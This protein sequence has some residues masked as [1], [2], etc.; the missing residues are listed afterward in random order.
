MKKHFLPGL[1][2][3]FIAFRFTGSRGKVCLAIFILFQIE[4]FSRAFAQC[5]G[6]GV[7]LTVQNPSFDGPSQAH[8]VPGPW[9][10]CYGTPD[11][12][13]GQWGFTQAPSDG[14]AYISALQGGNCDYPCGYSE[15]ASQQLSSCM[16]AGTTY[17]FSLDLAFSTVYN[18]AEPGSC[19]GSLQIMGGNSM[20]GQTEILWQSGMIT[21]TSWQTYTI[22]LTPSQNWCY[23]SMRPYFISSCSGYINIM[24][25]NLGPIIPP[26][27][28]LQATVNSDISCS[29]TI[30]GEISCPADSIILS[31]LFNGSPVYANILTDSTWSKNVVYPFGSAGTQT[32]G[33]TAYTQNGDTLVDTLTFNLVEIT[34]DFS[35]VDVCYGEPINFTCTSTITSGTIVSHQWDFGDGTGTS[36]LQNPSYT[37]SAP[38]AYQ[39]QLIVA[40]DLGC[41][42]S[43]TKTVQVFEKPVAAFSVLNVCLNVQSQFNNQST[44]AS[45]SLTAASWDFG[46]GAGTSTLASPFYTYPSTGTYNVS[47][48]VTSDN[49]CTDTL[50]KSTVVNPLPIADFTADN[51]CSGNA[52]NF[53]N[54][55][56]ISSGNVLSFNWN[57]G[58]LS[59]SSQENPSHVYN[60]AGNYN[61]SLSV[62]SDS[63]CAGSISKNMVV[64]PLPAANF[65]ATN[66]CLDN[67]ATFSNTSTIS[68]GNI[69]SWYWDFGDSN[70]STSQNTSHQYSSAGNFNVALIAISDSSCSDTVVKQLQIYPEP[71]AAFTANNVC[72]YDSAEFADGSTVSSGSISSF[73]W[74]FDDGF[75]SSLQNPSHLYGSPGIYNIIFTV[76]TNNGC[77][78]SATQAITI[79]TLPVAAFSTNDV[80]QYTAAQFTDAS[81]IASG[82]VSS[83]Q[84][85][86]ND[87]S[88]SSA[89]N[90]SHNFA[91]EGIYNVELLVTS[92]NGC[93]DS[94]TQPVT[95]FPVPQADFSF[96]NKCLYDAVQFTDNT[97]I[98]GGSITW[99]WDFGDGVSSSLQNPSHQYSADGTYNVVLIVIS[100]NNCSDTIMKQ[101][102]I[103]P[104]PLADFS[105]VDNCLSDTADF[106]DLSTISGGAIAGWGWN[107]G[108]GN[109]SVQQ[110]PAHL[111]SAP[112]TYSVTLIV[113]SGFGCTDSI[114]QNI[115]QFPMPTANFDADS[116]CLNDL[117]IFTDLSNGNG[118]NISSWTWILGDGSAPSSVQNPS[119]L[120]ASDGS[121][122]VTLLVETNNG[123]KD[124]KAIAIPV[125]PLP[126]ADFVNDIVC[127]NEPPTTFSSTSSVT[128][129]I[130]TAWDWNFGDNLTSA[131]QNPTHTYQNSGLFNTQLI[132]TTD[133]GCNDTIIKQVEVYALPQFNF[134][135]DKTAHC[136][137]LCANFT[138]NAAPGTSVQSWFW[139]FGDGN[140]SPLSGP[141]NCYTPDGTYSVQLIA[142]SMDNCRDTVT[143]PDYIMVF[144]NPTAGFDFTPQTTTILYP[145]I[146]FTDMS[147]GANS[148]L[149]DFGDF[150]TASY[151]NP[152]H[153][154]SD[155]G[156]FTVMQV[157]I[158]QFQCKDTIYKTV[159]IK[160][161]Y[162]IYIPNAFTPDGD[163]INDIFLPEGAGFTSE[164]YSLLIF[165]RWGD[166][167][168]ETYNPN[169]FWDGYVNGTLAKQDVYVFRLEVQ[170]F[171]GT[172]HKFIGKVSLLNR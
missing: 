16:I 141:S 50:T 155:T 28:G 108:D 143:K 92:D 1:I 99:D 105:F 53:T 70:N 170:D 7:E 90:P 37:Y 167:V 68:T 169:G 132:V 80:C 86:F 8:V 114:T 74:D 64:N 12:Q 122:N 69:A 58:D 38:G 142:T 65:S 130:I 98:S 103:Y 42:D 127:K 104:V 101:D 15:G 172:P 9:Q 147:A 159:I 32:I 35:P 138:A 85:D 33:I 14:T 93:S 117:T 77:V 82:S 45:G 54:T 73:I 124:Y 151:Q 129:G 144:P 43:I 139:D 96:D 128:S 41:I 49:G 66:V 118:D 52:M 154:Y 87:G 34:P 121:Y 113:S 140:T 94:V 125:Y 67:I 153:E 31:G 46:D 25:D 78:D 83:Y 62:N 36:S 136:D 40:S 55:S 152:V 48:I 100:G 20:C 106:T 111:Y 137:P 51:V 44:I 133:K 97:V 135:S 89:Q 21:N 60:G 102:T 61:V 161:E 2:F 91:S 146:D 163:G 115:V 10:A 162:I 72:K 71:D 150:D 23:I 59:T 84:W 107:F 11:T 88:N 168:Y 56:T 164:H 95:I 29:Q 5:G 75:N 119:H 158:N 27:P 126:A 30:N 160:T 13:P 149:W 4:L 156:T 18:T 39:V 3:S 17:S 165:D 24:I 76:A 116:V 26:S 47:L 22:S 120:Y 79:F 157:V 81:T 109:N 6:V 19:Y 123:C 166:L 134:G 148:W 171:F 145:E 57:F 112:G 110:N 63:G 131:L